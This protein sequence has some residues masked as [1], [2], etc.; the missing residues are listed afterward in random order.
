MTRLK[1]P[2]LQGKVALITGGGRGIGK[3][4]A[5]GFAQEGAALVLCGRTL[6]ALEEVCHAVHRRGGA[7]IPVQADV[8]R[9]AD[10]ARV[11][12][13]ALAVFGQI[14]ILVNNAGV[15]GPLGLITTLSKQAWD[16]TLAINLTGMFLCA[17]AVLEPMIAR[18]TGNIINL[19]SGAGLK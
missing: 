5:L 17:R 13:Q 14:D 9:E 2:R 4:I 18:R 8:A 7:A 12:D 11:R 15:A 3:A 6:A 1:T 16:D 10:V 19:S